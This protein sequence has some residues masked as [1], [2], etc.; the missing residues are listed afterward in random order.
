M[1]AYLEGRYAA[2]IAGLERWLSRAPGDD[3]GALA[4]LA[5]AA[6]SRVSALAEGPEA[7]ELSAAANALAARTRPFSPRASMER[8][9]D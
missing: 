2:A 5:F 6:L 1:D 9:A 8:S 7:A 3:Q 4:D